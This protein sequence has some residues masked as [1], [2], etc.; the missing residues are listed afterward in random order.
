VQLPSN[1][2]EQ[3]LDSALNALRRRK[4]VDERAFRRGYRYCALSRNLQVLGAFGFLT[5]VGRKAGFE[6]YIPAALRS[7]RG[8]MASEGNR[9]F[10]KL[11]RLVES[12]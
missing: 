10:A 6:P 4:T 8:M 2:R 11:R 3:L 12:L 9:R 1:L 7:L 5:R